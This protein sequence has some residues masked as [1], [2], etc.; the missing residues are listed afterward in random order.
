ML[1]HTTTITTTTTTTVASLASA[2][3][4]SSARARLMTRAMPITITGAQEDPGYTSEPHYIDYVNASIRTRGYLRAYPQVAEAAL[5]H[6]LEM[7]VVRTAPL[8]CNGGKFDF[9]YLIAATPGRA[10]AY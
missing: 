3:G 7:Y 5:P 10:R 8:L 6:V 2:D 1:D 9:V 4:L